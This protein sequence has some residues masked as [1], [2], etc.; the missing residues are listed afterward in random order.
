MNDMNLLSY[1]FVEGDYALDLYSLCPPL[2]EI[3]ILEDYIT[4][5]RTFLN[6]E[7]KLESW[8]LEQ[9]LHHSVVDV[10]EN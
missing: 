1:F 10:A 7:Q 9:R 5:K 4:G 8:I 3:H 6:L 2:R